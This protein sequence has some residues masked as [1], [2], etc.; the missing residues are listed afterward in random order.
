MI[1]EF[2]CEKCGHEWVENLALSKRN[3]PLD[4]H[5]PNC[6]KVGHTIRKFSSNI[7][8]DT[9]SSGAISRCSDGFN[10]LLK[11]MKKGA[12]RGNTINTK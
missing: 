10:D 2:E 3:E 9:K 7:V 12:G 11:N 8:G 4:S 6:K 1:Y 5:C